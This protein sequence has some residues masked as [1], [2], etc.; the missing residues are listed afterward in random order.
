MIF[1]LRRGWNVRLSGVRS[2]RHAQRNGLLR[3][4]IQF[5]IARAKRE[6]NLILARIQNAD[7]FLCA[8]RK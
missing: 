8:S 5:T 2:E 7:D 3:C 4:N 6:A 1:L